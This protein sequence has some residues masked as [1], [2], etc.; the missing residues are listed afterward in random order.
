VSGKAR[1]AAAVAVAV[2]VAD[3]V[4][5]WVVR[6]T[7]HLG[8]SVPVLGEVVR[9]TYILNPGAAFGLRV[10]DHS[11]LVFGVLAAVATVVLVAVIRQTPAAERV[12]VVSLSLILGGAVGN[13]VDR[14]R[15][16]HGVVDFLDVGLGAFRWPVFNLADVGVTTG[17]LLLVLFLW[18]EERPEPAAAER[19]PTAPGPPVP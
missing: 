7:F 19:D 15:H 18:G 8:E 17:A 14:L 4:T 11:R 5:K 3:A 16:P 2:V 10:G 6:E 1:L 12:R 9:L 13:L